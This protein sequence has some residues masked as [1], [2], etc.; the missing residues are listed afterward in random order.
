MLRSRYFL[1]AFLVLALSAVSFASADALT[2]PYST[3]TEPAQY[4]GWQPEGDFKPGAMAVDVTLWPVELSSAKPKNNGL[5]DD[6]GSGSGDLIGG[7][8]GNF[9]L[10]MWPDGDGLRPCNDGLNAK[11]TSSKVTTCKVSD[12]FT[13]VG[14]LALGVIRRF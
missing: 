11:V 3:M 8:S 10:S 9:Q 4:V 2:S 7:G 1:S 12:N 14:G 13:S 6:I 5:T